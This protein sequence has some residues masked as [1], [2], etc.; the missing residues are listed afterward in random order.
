M[1]SDH[2]LPEADVGT[3]VFAVRRLFFLACG[4]FL[5]CQTEMA[6]WRWLARAVMTDDALT[7]TRFTRL[8]RLS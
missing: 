3:D 4:P 7:R 2:L 1:P 5:F 6:R 8:T